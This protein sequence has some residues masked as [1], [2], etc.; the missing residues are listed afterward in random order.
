SLAVIVLALGLRP[1]LE[2]VTAWT[3]LLVKLAFVLGIVALALSALNRVSRPGGEHRTSVGLIAL[4][5]VGIMI[6]AAISLFSAPSS[7][8]EGMVVGDQW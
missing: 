7:H 3:F 1:D 5:F 4:P 2:Q 6:L 8:W